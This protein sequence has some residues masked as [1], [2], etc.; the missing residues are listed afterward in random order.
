MRRHVGSFIATMDSLGYVRIRIQSAFENI[1][2]RNVHFFHLDKD[3]ME[4]SIPMVQFLLKQ[5]RIAFWPGHN[6]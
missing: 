5:T 2:I 4:Y 3:T 6:G 1:P